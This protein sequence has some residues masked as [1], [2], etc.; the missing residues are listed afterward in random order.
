MSSLALKSKT[1]IRE[2]IKSGLYKFQKSPCFCGS[3]HSILLAQMDGYGNYYP[4]VICKKCG[5][6]R[7]DPRLTKDAYIDFYTHEYRTLH[8]WDDRDK[9]ERWLN[10][11]NQAKKAYEFIK[12]QIKIPQKSVVFD[13]GCYMGAMLLPF[14]EDGH[15]VMGVDYDKK[16]IEYG[17]KKTSL[18][19]EVGNMEKLRDF[20]KKADLIILNHVLEHLLDLED[21]LNTIREVMKLNGFIFIAAPGTFWIHNLSRGN[22]IAKLQNAHLWQFSLNS[23]RYVMECCGFELVYGDEEIKSIF[24]VGNAFREKK[25]I[26]EEELAKVIT[27]LKRTERKYLP[28]SYVIR[29]LE[30]LGAKK[31]VRSLIIKFSNGF[32]S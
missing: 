20:G 19:L 8:G 15:E 9:D 3:E 5:L 16:S 26:P 18:N 6:V 14:Y 29:L 7:A 12:N 30:F 22:I 4:L 32:K 27:Y 11:M 24:R 1:R 25:D 28:K 23:L 31:M 17:R 21:E 10:K 13:I 2:K